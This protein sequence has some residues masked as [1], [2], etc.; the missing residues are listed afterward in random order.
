MI[1]H[2]RSALYDC[3]HGAGFAAVLPAWMEVVFPHD[4]MYFARFAVE[5]FGCQMDYA[6]PERTG[7]EGI[8]VLRNFFHRSLGMPM[9][10]KDLGEGRKI[11]QP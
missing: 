2:E 8:G 10:L 6:Q 7:G 9:T 4:P 3:A 11:P 5:V 1:E